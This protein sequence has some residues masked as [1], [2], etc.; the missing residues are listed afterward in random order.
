VK[1]THRKYTERK[2][3]NISTEWEKETVCSKVTRKERD[4]KIGQILQENIDVY[5]EVYVLQLL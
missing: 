1:V 3:N 2:I 5:L 4:K